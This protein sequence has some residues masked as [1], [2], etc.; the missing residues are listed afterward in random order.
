VA[1][2]YQCDKCQTFYTDDPYTLEIRDATGA[3]LLLK[4]LCAPCKQELENLFT[5]LKDRYRW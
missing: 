3:I 4:D 1:N 5:P 2:A